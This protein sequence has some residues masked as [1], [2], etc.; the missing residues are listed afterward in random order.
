MNPISV[1]LHAGHGQGISPLEY[2][3]LVLLY[4]FAFGGIAVL[5][6]SLTSVV[7]ATRSA[8]VDERNGER[9]DPQG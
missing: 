9:N 3:Y 7:E 8:F 6:F 5:V 2:T 4:L 1:A